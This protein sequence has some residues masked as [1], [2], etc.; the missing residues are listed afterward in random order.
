[1]KTLAIVYHYFAHYREPVLKELCRN[2]SDRYQIRLIA[3]N[4][5]EI[6]SLKTL[7][8]KRISTSDMLVKRVEN[9]WLG[10]FLWQRG[11]LRF[12]VRGNADA[13]I[14]LGQFNFLSTWVGILLARLLGKKTYFWSH[15]VYGN[16]GRLKRWVRVSFYRL[17]HGMFLYGDYSKELLV[18]YGMS[19]KN[20]HVIYNSLDYRLQRRL[21]DE[22]TEALVGSIRTNLFGQE[23]E[24][25]PYLLFV[26][27]LT[28]VKRLDLLV[29]AVA[30]LNEAGRDVNCLFI[31]EGSEL[32]NL[33]SLT[34]S[35]CIEDR[36]RFY[37]AC[38]DEVELSDLIYAGDVCVAP[39]NVGLTAMHALSYGTPVV[40]HDDRC[41]QMPEFEAITPGVT[42]EFFERNNLSALVNRIEEV[43][44]W[45]QY[46]R[47]GVRLKCF[48][49]IDQNYNPENQAR[50][51]KE[52]LDSD[53]S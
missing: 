9:I 47:K 41:W 14:F 40:T 30:E 51:I 45:C 12:I 43:L 34:A 6:P 46:D 37:G 42:G 32:G 7:D 2:L 1:M 17:A 26:G 36:V 11:L 52:V 3:D 48:K 53:L 24:K 18:S 25:R 8:L 29:R 13:I 38:H 10:P 15:G 19:P 35:L 44:D 16:E 28:E 27:R 23:A 22:K 50:L 39:G 31:G 4:K 33:R 21:R 49:V 20:L 5:A